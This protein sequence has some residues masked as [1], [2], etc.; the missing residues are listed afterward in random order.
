MGRGYFPSFLNSEGGKIKTAQNPPAR[1]SSS[2]SDESR[3]KRY[4]IKLLN[5]GV[6]PSTEIWMG[7]GNGG[8]RE[9]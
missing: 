9:T 7:G 3:T 6:F 8:W 5:Y 2:K 1:S 4:L